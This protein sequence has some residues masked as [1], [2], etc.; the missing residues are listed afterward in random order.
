MTPRTPS[1]K[2]AADAGPGDW[3]H[4]ALPRAV[5]ERLLRDRA[6]VAAEL[7]CLDAGAAEGTRRA[8]L[9]SLKGHRY[10]R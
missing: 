8:I 7:R 6:L 4:V 2:P 10:Q 3:L 9:C 1:L 5:L